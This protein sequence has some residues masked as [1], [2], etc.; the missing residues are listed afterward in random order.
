[1]VPSQGLALQ[2]IGEWSAI[3]PAISL[4]ALQGHGWVRALAKRGYETGSGDELL[5]HQ[6]SV[7]SVAASQILFRI[8]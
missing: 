1:M 8:H 6:R 3:K 7:A 2:V 5:S 4:A